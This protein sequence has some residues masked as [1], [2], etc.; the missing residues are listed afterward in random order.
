M[1]LE[2]LSENLQVKRAVSVFKGGPGWERGIGSAAQAKGPGM[3]KSVGKAEV[4]Q[5]VLDRSRGSEGGSEGR[6]HV[7]ASSLE[8]SCF[9]FPKLPSQWFS[10]S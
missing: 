4:W 1:R 6:Q 3:E 8:V 9:L 2:Q 7:Q 10:A 5:P